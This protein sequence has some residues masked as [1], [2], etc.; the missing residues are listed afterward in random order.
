[1]KPIHLR[2]SVL[3]D[4]TTLIEHIASWIKPER[5]LEIG[6]FDGINMRKVQNWAHECYGVDIQIRNRNY[7]ENVKLF[8]MASDEFFKKLDPSIKFDMAFID[9]DHEKNQVYKDFINVENRIIQDGIVLMHDS[10]PMNDYMLSPGLCNDA[11]EAIFRIKNEFLTRWEIVSL[12][13]NPGLT[14]MRK[15]PVNKQLLWK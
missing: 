1:M 4:H 12:P 7:K 14:I 13:M 5:Y 8:E 3:H 2:N 9:G 10:V 11:W 6:V 15:M